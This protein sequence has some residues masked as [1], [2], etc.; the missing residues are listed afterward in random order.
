MN[1]S[2]S[3]RKTEMLKKDN[4][5]LR[6]RLQE[7]KIDSENVDNGA[8]EAEQRFMDEDIVE[9]RFKIEYQAKNYQQLQD[10]Y[11]K[12]NIV[13]DQISGWAK[14]VYTKFSVLTDDAVLSRQPDD[15][16]KIF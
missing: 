3:E 8:G 12:V 10:R 7:L 1:V 14:R 6:Q 16:I 2:D 11:K 13:N 4:D 5:E 15:M 9:M